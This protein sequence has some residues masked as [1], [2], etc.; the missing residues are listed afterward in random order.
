MAIL[1]EP[2]D[3]PEQSFLVSVAKFFWEL[4]KVVL[5]AVIIIVPVRYFLIQPFFVRGASMEPSFEDGEYLIIDEL[6]YQ[7]REPRRGEVIVFRFPDNPSQF[8]IKRIIGLPGETVRVRDGQVVVF[9]AQ[10]PQGVFI[11]ESYLPEG[12]RT[13]GQVEQ[14][15]GEGEYFVLG[16]NRVASSDSRSWGVLP[17]DD[18]IGRAWIRAFPLS[19]VAIFEPE[20]VGFV[21]L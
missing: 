1:M 11:D 17:F 7:F 6:S 9:N 2:S 16:D 10:F 14:T 5:V 21:S 12:L 3:A 20:M 4:I 15:L 19:R 13:G 8:F 18:I